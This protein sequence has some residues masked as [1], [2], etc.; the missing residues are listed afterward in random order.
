MHHISF[1]LN[2]KNYVNCTRSPLHKASRVYVGP[3]EGSRPKWRLEPVTWTTLLLLQGSTFHC[4]LSTFVTNKRFHSTAAF[5]RNYAP[6]NIRITIH[7]LLPEEKINS[8]L[9]PFNII[10]ITIFFKKFLFSPFHN[11]KITIF[12]Q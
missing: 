10:K 8:Y 3:E 1:L 4:S 12:F 6:F 5:N 9:V 2:D 11:I 7:I